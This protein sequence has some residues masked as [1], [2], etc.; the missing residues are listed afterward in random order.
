MRV[1]GGVEEQGRVGPQHPHP[2]EAEQGHG[3]VDG[4]TGPGGADEVPQQAEHQEH[5]HHQGD[6]GLALDVGADE[7][8]DGGGQA[9][10]GGRAV[11]G[12]AQHG[13]DLDRGQAD[14]GDDD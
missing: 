14:G 6:G 3:H 13:E 7:Q 2:H 11:A 4:G 9:Q 1:Q 5:G 8:G 12:P 10:E